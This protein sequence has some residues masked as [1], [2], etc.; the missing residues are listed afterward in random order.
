MNQPIALVP[1]NCKTRPYTALEVP[2]F[3]IEGEFI[4]FAS[5]DSTYAV[6]ARLLRGAKSSILIGI[7]DFTASYVRDF[8]IDAVKRGVRVTLMLDLDNRKGENELWDS[9]AQEGAECIPAP[10]CASRRARYFPSCHEKVIVIDGE[11]TLVQSGNYSPASIPCNT[12]DGGV[13]SQFAP[14]NR[15]MG[16]AVHSAPLAQ[17]FTS[18]LEADIALEVNSVDELPF[19]PGFEEAPPAL[20]DVPAPPGV[21]PR[22]YH[23]RTYQPR[24]PLHVT[25]V[26]SPDNY[27]DVVLPLLANARQS[28]YIEQQYIRPKGQHITRLLEAIYSARQANPRLKVRIILAP[29]Q[30]TGKEAE[31]ENLDILRAYDFLLGRQ[32]RYLNPAFFVHCHNKMIIVDRRLT[33]VSS[34]NWSDSAVSENRE[35]GLL[36]DSASLARY[37]A[38]MFTLDWGTA[39]RNLDSYSVT[40]PGEEAVKASLGDYVEV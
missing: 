3:E 28:I 8:L 31:T 2:D 21:P 35:A 6:T 24:K 12:I 27:L 33:L 17:F 18:M 13:R 38:R 20:F 40:Q 15:D 39:L 37:Y 36:L 11:W 32:V 30:W 5:P 7:Y 10:S 16:I 29:P 34:Q 19:G 26:I 14:G 25:P 23:S 1:R 9:L 22:L 4:A